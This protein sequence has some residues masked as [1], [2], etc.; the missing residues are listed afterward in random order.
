[1]V[2]NDHK[3]AISTFFSAKSIFITGGTG[4]I[5]K[6]IIEKLLR[7][8]SALDRIYVL[9]RPKHGIHVHQRIEQLCSLPAIRLLIP[10]FKTKII[11]VLGDITKNEFD[12]SNE[13]QQL[14]IE[15]CQ[16]VINSGAS[17][18]FTEPLK[19]A[20]K[21]NLY[22]VRNMINLCKKMQ[23]LQSFVH[24]STAYIHPYRLDIDEV[25]YPMNEDPNL[26]L[27]SIEGFSEKM[28]DYLSKKLLIN[29]PNTYTY[30]K[31][32]AEYLILQQANQ[33]PIGE[34]LS[35]LNLNIF[36]SSFFFK[37]AIIRPSIVG[38]TW[39][40]PIPESFTN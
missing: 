21:S 22:S 18:R 25:L 13:D 3:S 27:E 14:L 34:E 30:T 11:P 17:V 38:A 23:Q 24:I 9:V 28:F 32:L 2:E 37:L 40:E 12:L 36:F 7:S 31:S 35:Q 33:L 26:L 5:G 19:Q 20:I 6:Q 1:M 10:N 16:I 39:N 15:N 29:Y 8:C 4:F